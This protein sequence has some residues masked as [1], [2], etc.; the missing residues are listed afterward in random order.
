MLPD[1]GSYFIVF[2]L[3]KERKIKC[4][5]AWFTRAEPL[6]TSCVI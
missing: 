6:D 5:I 3:L 1:F 4:F 2:F